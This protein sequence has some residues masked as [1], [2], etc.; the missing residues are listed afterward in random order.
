MGWVQV[1]LDDEFW[2]REE[3]GEGSGERSGDDSKFV[4]L[5]SHEEGNLSLI[6]CQFDTRVSLDFSQRSD[7]GQDA[8]S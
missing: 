2:E 6:S 5:I 4:A 3:G 8:G 1:H 7:C